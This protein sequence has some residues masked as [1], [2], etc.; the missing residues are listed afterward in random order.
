MLLRCIACRINIG[1]KSKAVRSPKPCTLNDVKK[2]TCYD[3]HR[4]LINSKLKGQTLD[5]IECAS[6]EI[7][8]D[9]VIRI[10]LKN[11]DQVLLPVLA[12]INGSRV[13]TQAEEF[14]LKTLEERRLQA[15]RQAQKNLQKIDCRKIQGIT[16]EN[17]CLT[18]EDRREW[19]RFLGESYPRNYALAQRYYS[20]EEDPMLKRLGRDK[21]QYTINEYFE[22]YGLPR[23]FTDKN[24]RIQVVN[25]RY[26]NTTQG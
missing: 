23:I 19:W 25:D 10:K 15:L 14:E 17:F 13:L 20:S 18:D 6:I 26:D 4:E 3:R 22:I 11:H 24:H 1:G 12:F 8:N 2:L 16:E 5:E 9:Y 7:V 21:K